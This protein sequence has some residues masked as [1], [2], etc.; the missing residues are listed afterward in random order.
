M[1]QLKILITGACGGLGSA[2]ATQL[3]KRGANLL[4]LDKSSRELDALSDQICAQGQEP[5][6]IC[7]LD[8]AK[9]G[10]DE[11]HSL[12]NILRLEYCGL[13]V[14][15]HCAAAFEGLQPMD[16]VSSEQWQA[17]MH[18]NV[19][20]AWLITTTCLPLL[21]AGGKGRVV[22][23]YEN[24]AIS[25][26]AYWGAYG[27]SKAALRSLGQILDQELE[28]SGVKIIEA[29]PEP[30]RT[31]L[32]ARAYLAEDPGTLLDPVLAAGS[33]IKQLEAS[34]SR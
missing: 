7:P 11:F 14:I 32:R 16:L 33:I 22:F 13:D 17:C 20:A 31:A 34:Y 26:S 12:A 28:G 2:L 29:C 15:I 18:V 3:A 25:G 6:G 1:K 5:P 8:L 4:L 10:P 23:V 30:M 9:S 21:K 24:K 27:V 19:S